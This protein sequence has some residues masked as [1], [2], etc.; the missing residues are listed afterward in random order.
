MIKKR[1]VRI[2]AGIA[3][4]LVIVVVALSYLVDEPLRRYAEETLNERLKGYTVRIG[5]LTTHPL[6]LSA[7][8]ESVIII[9]QENPTPPL[10]EIGRIHGGVHWLDLL[11][12][13]IVADAR[14][15]KPRVFVN[16]QKL[17]TEV[18]KPPSRKEAWQDTVQAL[19]PITLNEIRIRNGEVVYLAA[20]AT[21]PV[22]IKNLSFT[23]HNIQN[24]KSPEQAYPSDFFLEAV[25]FESP[26][27]VNGRAD[28]LR[29]PRPAVRAVFEVR[30]LDL[31][32]FREVASLRQVDLKQGV[33]SSSGSIEISPER[34]VFMLN[35]LL[36][37]DAI[38]DYEYRT[39]RVPEERKKEE[40]A[41][42]AEK[43]KEVQREFVDKPGML[44]KAKRIRIA[45]GTFGLVNR[46]ADPP[47]RVFMKDLDLELSNFSNRFSEG[48]AELFLKAQFMGS[49]DTSASGTFRPEKEGPD[50]TFRV[51]IKNTGMKAMNDMF[52]AYGKFDVEKGLFS[53]YSELTVK[54]NKVSGYVKPLFR[55]VKVYDKRTDREKGEFRKL[56]EKIVG[57][58]TKLLENRPRDTVATETP[59]RGTVENP[60]AGT[61]DT[62]VNLLRNAFFQ[63][64][65]P[66]FE[67]SIGS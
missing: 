23:A 8:V 12:G 51:A 59:I 57:G 28:L 5:K 25:L 43:V 64:V 4:V 36:L 19:A 18:K 44:V 29:K 27:T 42:T 1:W 58:V 65:L 67:E 14:V 66:G 41:K 45:R 11:T 56:Y 20:G 34:I 35:D 30:E 47:Y 38:A 6:R 10:A 49:G 50:F 24:V 61:W 63:A 40:K 54:N 13:H 46:S 48:P 7:D 15:E 9:Q 37:A 16:I 31:S 2:A 3:V 39:A 22:T 53:F 26:V 62:L 17:K 52:R 33:F 21:E 32:H 60:Q 55:D